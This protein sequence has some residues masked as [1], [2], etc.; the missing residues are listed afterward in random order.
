MAAIRAAQPRATVG[1]TLN[2]TVG[3]PASE[4]PD[5]AEA[6]RRFDRHV[7]AWF[8]DPLFGRGYPADLVEFYGSAMPRVSSAELAEI[9]APIDFLGLNFYFPTYVRAVPPAPGHEHGA[10]WLSGAELAARGFEVTEMGWPVVP[11]TFRDM[12][13]TV[14]E[15]YRP[16]ALY[17]TENGAAFPDTLV[18][19]AVH[20]PRRVAYLES[21]LDAAAQA[22]ENGVPL[23]GYFVWSLLDNF[24]WAHGYSKRFG[25]IY[26]DYV[27][28][29]R[30][31]K[32]SFNWYK[33]LI[34]S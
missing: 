18:D 8:L 19:G 32:D 17:V 4:S 30:I 6:A 25:L 3:R 16:S 26:I 5:D 10:Q 11:D 1:I 12:L 34:S 33:K 9:A 27:T 28:Q 14:H 7:N 2:T 29:K 15:T 22:L 31:V 23:R 24:E 13:V 20:D 21:H